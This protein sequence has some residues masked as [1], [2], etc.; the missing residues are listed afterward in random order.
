M[1]NIVKG[2][3]GNYTGNY[4]GPYWSNGKVQ[5]SVEWGDTDP[6][7]ELDYLSRQHD[8][9]YA[10]FKDDKHRSAA[11]L[12][13]NREAQKLKEKFPSLAGNIVLYGNHIKRKGLE[14]LS[15]ARHGLPGLVYTAAGNIIDSYKMINGTYL[16]KELADVNEY[17]KTDPHKE[18]FAHKAPRERVAGS[19]V[20]PAG[21]LNGEP[22]KLLRQNA[23]RNFGA[24]QELAG[25]DSASRES[26]VTPLPKV[27]STD[28]R[29]EKLIASQARRFENYANLKK[30][31]EN[32]QKEKDIP[33]P[34]LGHKPLHLQK[35]YR[36]RKKNK[37]HISA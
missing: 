11:D 36:K 8:S 4:T 3:G 5:E 15:N 16:K 6:Q 32:S 18:R 20:S 10:K 25:R 35:A 33:I 17:F 14:T 21:K 22:S 26:K 27:D 24:H 19:F 37:I 28:Q 31:A 12:I 30:A 1:E 34:F 23:G 29:K 9:A 7:S 13:Y 2:I